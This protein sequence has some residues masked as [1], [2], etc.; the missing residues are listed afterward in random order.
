MLGFMLDETDTQETPV[1]ALAC[2]SCH[3]RLAQR[4]PRVVV[5]E[6][7][8]HRDCFEAAHQKRTGKRPILVAFNGDGVTFRPAA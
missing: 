7:T 1:R 3:I 6:E 4:A 5:G 2:G 8:Y